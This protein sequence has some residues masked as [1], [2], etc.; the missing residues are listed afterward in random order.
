M[1]YIEN[2]SI[3]LDFRNH[4]YLKSFIEAHKD[5]RFPLTGNNENGELVIV[6]AVADNVD[7]GTYQSNGYLMHHTYWLSREVEEWFES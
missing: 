1:G 7:V 3:D 5:D 4:A 2:N 6:S